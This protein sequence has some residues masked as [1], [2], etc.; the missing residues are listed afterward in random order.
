M[1]QP[2]KTSTW[3]ISGSSVHTI[4]KSRRETDKELVHA[5]QAGD[6]RSFEALM[7]R[8][9]NILIRQVSSMVRD[10]SE[11]ED[12]AQETFL[13]AYMSLHS[14]RGDSA[15]STWLYRIGI[16]TAKRNLIRSSRRLPQVS[17]QLDDGTGSQQRSDSETDYDT[18]EAKLESKQILS[19]LK[20]AL[21]N[22]PDEQKTT[23][24]LRELEGMSYEEIAAEMHCPVG[25]VRSRI[26]RA[27]DTIAAALKPP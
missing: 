23:L 22:L 7:K 15:F 20:A 25:T 24:V 9:K 26:S 10:L 13:K 2:G 1:S 16:N 21:D 14:F 8:Y 6:M 27:R 5:A 17:E 12:I 3:N 18:P 4:M 19:M 11:A